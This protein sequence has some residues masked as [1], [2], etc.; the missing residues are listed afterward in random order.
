MN[1]KIKSNQIKITINDLPLIDNSLDGVM[2]FRG[3]YT[4]SSFPSISNARKGDLIIWNNGITLSIYIFD[5]TQWV[6]ASGMN[7]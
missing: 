7:L 6:Q 1:T 2:R 5:G 4:G 3:V